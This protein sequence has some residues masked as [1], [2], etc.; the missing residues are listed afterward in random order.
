ML[1]IF[2]QHKVIREKFTTLREQNGI[3]VAH[4][5]EPGR[6]YNGWDALLSNMNHIGKFAAPHQDEQHYLHNRKMTV[7]ILDEIK[8]KKHHIKYKK[9]LIQT[10][11][12]MESIKIAEM[13]KKWWNKQFIQC[14]NILNTL[15][16]RMWSLQNVQAALPEIINL[17]NSSFVF[18]YFIYFI[19]F[20]KTTHF[21]NKYLK[22]STDFVQ[23]W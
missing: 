12:Q 23:F 1:C 18:F 6:A 17:L 3:Y 21:R 4:Q 9:K 8:Q 19:Y 10:I 5:K 2:S 15:L 22:N 20:I 13:I 7:S 11:K 14:Y 16:S